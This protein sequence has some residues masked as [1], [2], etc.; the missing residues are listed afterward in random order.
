MVVQ[1]YGLYSLSCKR[2]RNTMTMHTIYTF[3]PT[4]MGNGKDKVELKSSGAGYLGAAERSSQNA[5]LL[6]PGLLIHFNQ[7]ILH[8]PPL[9]SSSS[10]F[11]QPFLTLFTFSRSL[12]DPDHAILPLSP[13][14]SFSINPPLLHI[15]FLYTLHILLYCLSLVYFAPTLTFL[16]YHLPIPTRLLLLE[17]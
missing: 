13:P 11:N 9:M 17:L 12:Q 6:L 1:K 14:V 7:P 3:K 10:S 15:S 5:F 16:L 2:N 4:L 8:I